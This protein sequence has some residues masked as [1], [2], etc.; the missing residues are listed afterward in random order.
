MEPFVEQAYT[1]PS[2]KVLPRCLV[3]TNGYEPDNEQGANKTKRRLPREGST[4]RKHFIA[5]LPRR[6][7]F[8]VRPERSHNV[9]IEFTNTLYSYLN[10]ESYRRW[11]RSL[12]FPHTLT[13][14][15]AVSLSLPNIV[16]HGLEKELLV[17]AVQLRLE[18]GQRDDAWTTGNLHHV[19][20]LFLVDVVDDL[21]LFHGVELGGHFS[22]GQ[23]SS[24]ANKAKTDGRATNVNSQ[25]QTRSAKDQYFTGGRG[26]I[27]S[28]IYDPW[29]NTSRAQTHSHSKDI[30]CGSPTVYP[31]WVP[32]TTEAMPRR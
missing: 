1:A 11:K 3:P 24:L 4:L 14:T 26:G 10:L 12:S 28:L 16:I 9:P 21:G 27:S 25:R 19:R 22:R 17:R 5:S 32:M 30:H 2:S 23:S 6:N 18:I 29:N 15:H 7:T 31:R 13:R 8:G 20:R